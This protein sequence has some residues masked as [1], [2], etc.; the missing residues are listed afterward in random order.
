MKGTPAT[1]HWLMYTVGSR[2][3]DKH[4][5]PPCELSARRPAQ[6]PAV[7]GVS[8]AQS[9]LRLLYPHPGTLNHMLFERFW[10]NKSQS[11]SN[12]FYWPIPLNPTGV[13]LTMWE[14]F[15]LFL[16]RRTV[17]ISCSA[18]FRASTASSY[19][20]FSMSN[21]PNIASLAAKDISLYIGWKGAPVLPHQDFIQS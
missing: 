21:W 7:P 5:L 2:R 12:A 6:P 4:A 9:V 11:C 20:A 14:D 16:T 8:L 18:F 19:L 15:Q 17:S 10:C 13:N 3:T 1:R